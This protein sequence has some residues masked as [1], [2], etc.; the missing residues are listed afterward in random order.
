MATENRAEEKEQK[1]IKVEILSI[2]SVAAGR[3]ETAN[4]P[5]SGETSDPV[6]RN[7]R[8]QNELLAIVILGKEKYRGVLLQ[9]QG[10]HDVG[11]LR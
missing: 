7:V 6:G 4:T 8:N 3:G 10:G 1:L 11:S 5:S 9:S 2:V